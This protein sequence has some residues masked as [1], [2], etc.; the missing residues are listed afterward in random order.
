MYLVCRLLLEKKNTTKHNWCT[1]HRGPSRTHPHLRLV[2]PVCHLHLLY[3]CHADPP[4]H[5]SFP[6]RRSSDL[7]E[8]GVRR[9]PGARRNSRD[10]MFGHRQPGSGRRPRPR[11]RCGHEFASDRKSTRLNSSHRCISYAVFCLKKKTQLN[12]TGVLTTVDRLV[13]TL[14]CVLSCLSA[15]CI[16]STPATPTPHIITLS[17]HDALPI[18]VNEECAGTLELA[19]IRGM[20]C[21]VTGS[22]EADGDHGPG[23]DVDMNSH[24]IGRAHV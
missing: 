4:H 15:T 1:D 9:Y 24:Q 12:T 7:R 18:S 3:S 10:E 2:L 14:T 23:A 17:L 8:R 6:T 13:L 11:C 22:Q 20:K 19:A 21:L 5:H 16:S